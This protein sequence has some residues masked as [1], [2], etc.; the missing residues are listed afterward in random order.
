MDFVEGLPK[1]EGYSMI[2]VVVDR[3]SKSTH[4]MPLKQPFPATTEA[5][6][7]IREVIRLHG[8]PQPVM[9]DKDKVF[10]IRF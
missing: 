9:S 7:C 2:M 1:S 6:V 8:G 5:N 10:L 3:L 4:F